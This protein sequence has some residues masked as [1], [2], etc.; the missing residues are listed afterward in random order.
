L[1]LIYGTT[2]VIVFHWKATPTQ[3][4]STNFNWRRKICEFLRIR[5]TFY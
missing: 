2:L 5:P 3:R 4:I 1:Q